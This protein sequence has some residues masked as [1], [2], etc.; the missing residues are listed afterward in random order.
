MRSI[1]NG[2]NSAS[3]HFQRDCGSNNVSPNDCGT[4]ES[5]FESC[6]RSCLRNSDNDNLRGRLDTIKP[7]D[8]IDNMHAGLYGLNNNRRV[9]N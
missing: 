5:N 9:S 7:R 4:T 8:R 6:S 3:F 2:V 1:K